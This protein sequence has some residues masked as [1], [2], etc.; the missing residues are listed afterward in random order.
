MPDAADE[1]SASLVDREGFEHFTQ[2]MIK[3]TV[4]HFFMGAD[5]VQTDAEL[6]LQFRTAV[7][8]AVTRLQ[9]HRTMPPAGHAGGGSVVVLSAPPHGTPDKPTVSAR[10]H[11]ATP[12]SKMPQ[13]K[14][15]HD[16]PPT[17]RQQQRSSGSARANMMQQAAVGK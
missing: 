13:D 4:G 3:E 8:E 2:T 5:H 12:Q 15:P 17:H 7:R 14:P 10:T 11:G 6:L 1:I 9:V 16:K